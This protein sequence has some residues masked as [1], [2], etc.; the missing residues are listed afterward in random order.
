MGVICNTIIPDFNHCPMT[1]DTLLQVPAVSLN[2]NI[3]YYI[4]Y[5]F[6]IFVL[7]IVHYEK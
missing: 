5:I 2:K 6:N 7:I 4:K 3:M 1:M